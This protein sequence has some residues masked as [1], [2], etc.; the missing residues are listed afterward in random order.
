MRVRTRPS[1]SS[2]AFPRAANDDGTPPLSDTKLTAALRHFS[3]HGLAAAKEAYDKAE[4]A[5]AAGDEREFLWWRDICEALDRR[6]ARQLP[7]MRDM[8]GLR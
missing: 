1:S 6:L 7:P 8:A 3:R 5:F 2:L 4:A